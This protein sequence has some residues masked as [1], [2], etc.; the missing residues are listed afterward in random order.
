MASDRVS[1]AHKRQ[2]RRATGRF[3]MEAGSA[4]F[5][6]R[7]HTTTVLAP[8]T[9][10]AGMRS[11]QLVI[12]D[13]TRADA[14]YVGE[15]LRASDLREMALLGLDASQVARSFDASD[16]AR[17]IE[18]AGRPVA[19]FGRAPVPGH[20]DLGAVWMLATDQLD[21]IRSDF[22]MACKPELL[23]LHDGCRRLGNLT[24]RTNTTVIRWLDW[25]GFTFDWGR[26]YGPGGEFVVFWR[27][28]E[29]EQHV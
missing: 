29:G 5:N 1:T 23:R 21:Q 28:H 2:P 25:L 26:P 6:R 8:A 19:V 3:R 16:I 7:M 17:T 22:V 13:A 14:E 20:Q 27:D 24:A 18:A 4:T 12:R 15:H 11:P 9:A 10:P